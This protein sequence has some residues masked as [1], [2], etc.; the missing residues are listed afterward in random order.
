MGDVGKTT[1]AAGPPPIPP[2]GT[3]G[4][5]AAIVHAA[6]AKAGAVD[7]TRWNSEIRAG[8]TTLRDTI[9]GATMKLDGANKAVKE[10]AEWMRVMS[11]LAPSQVEVQV[12]PTPRPSQL[13]DSWDL[14]EILVR[15]P[16]SQVT[17]DDATRFFAAKTVFDRIR[18]IQPTTRLPNGMRVQLGAVVVHELLKLANAVM[19][20][21][22]WTGAPHDKAEWIK[23]TV[24]PERLRLFDP[25]SVAH[26]AYGPS[27]SGAVWSGAFTVSRLESGGGA[28]VV[29]QTAPYLVLITI[30]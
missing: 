3:N 29:I 20:D 7:P 1:N 30:A 13:P 11:M 10:L 23:T 24:G 2:P 17:G 26:G 4:A 5:T 6:V 9:D 25:V 18:P 8:L 15:V 12:V 19:V 21:T 27:V 28:R 16:K 14:R 22:S